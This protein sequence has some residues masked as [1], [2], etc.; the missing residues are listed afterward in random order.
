MN[1]KMMTQTAF[2]LGMASHLM[3]L[4]LMTNFGLGA[5][6]HLLWIRLA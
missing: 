4:M 3:L 1:E 6:L 5:L 2:R